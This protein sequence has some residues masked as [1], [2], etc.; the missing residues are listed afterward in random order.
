[1]I[2]EILFYAFTFLQ[3]DTI[4]VKI[5]LEIQGLDTNT[6]SIQSPNENFKIEVVFG[7]IALIKGGR[8]FD[9][10]ININKST[11]LY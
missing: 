2:P 7:K 3:Q 10:F 5:H 6:V 4:P 1:M 8:N 11:F 9:L